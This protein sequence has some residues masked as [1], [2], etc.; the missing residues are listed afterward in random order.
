MKDNIKEGYKDSALGEIPD[1]WEVKTIDEIADVKGG[2]RLP[3]GEQ[4]VEEPTK[5]PYIR[6]TN[7][8]MGG[9]STSDML[10]VPENI[11]PLISR[12]TISEK[13]LFI[14]VAGTLGIVGCIPKELEGANL[15]EN[16]DKLTNIKIDK[17]FLLYVLSSS[18]IQDAIERDQTNNAQPKL[19]LTR[20]KT[21]LIPNPPLKEQK[22]IAE[23]LSTVDKKMD[24]VEQQIKE[25]KELKKGLMQ[26]LLV[27][28]IGHTKFKDSPLGQIPHSWEVVKLE[29]VCDVIDPHPS[30]RAPKEDSN[31]FPFVG[32]GD[33][34][35]FGDI[36]ITKVRK[37][38]KVDVLKQKETF[39]LK[40]YDMGFGRVASIGKV[41]WFKE[42][43]YPYGISPTM[44][45]IR[46][47][48]IDSIYINQFLK[49]YLTFK[50]FRLLS[51]GSTRT[52]IGMKSLRL[53]FVLIPPLK[54]QKQIAEILTT[55]DDKIDILEKKKSEIKDLKKGLMQQLLT[56]KI[57]VNIN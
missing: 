51:V 41:V 1:S 30:H 44:A 15:T 52:S 23:I 33:I 13:D 28:G 2:K 20:I 10:F 55:V 29:D 54:E 9:V 16:A 19:A 31:G 34:N 3:K 8:Y 53:L 6:V 5:H 39:V 47:K 57:R 32:I 17:D 37:I 18:F 27:K 45:L 14:S 38:S 40:K 56:G 25:T 46:A 26:K 50:Q 11:F 4:L 36:D 42:K 7:M 43:K 24:I 12:Y 35:E 21:F 49:S 22:K 48:D